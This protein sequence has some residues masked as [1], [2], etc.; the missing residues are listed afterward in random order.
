MNGILRHAILRT[1]EIANTAYI[2]QATYSLKI[3]HKKMLQ[4]TSAT[5]SNGSFNEATK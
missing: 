4:P 1:P 2:R 3:V 5:T